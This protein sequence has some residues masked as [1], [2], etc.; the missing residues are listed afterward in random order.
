[1]DKQPRKPRKDASLTMRMTRDT[2]DRL[3]AAA[4]A[5]GRSVSEMAERWLDLAADGAAGLEQRLGGGGVS[6]ALLAMADFAAEVR[7]QVGDPGTQLVA[8][9]ALLAGWAKMISAALP[10]TPDTQEGVAARMARVEARA[11]ARALLE[12]LLQTAESD[13]HS[14]VATWAL[15]PPPSRNALAPR[16][17]RSVVQLLLDYAEA[18][19]VDEARL[20][21]ALY[22]ALQSAPPALAAIT[23]APADVAGLILEAR[24]RLAAYMGPRVA[25]RKKGEA[26]AEARVPSLRVI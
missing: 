18:S 20:S 9:D 7:G 19:G 6:E 4:N 23:P 11:A 17:G 25:A 2:R 24:E 14:E 8:R 12:A 13:L 15:T 22:G 1:M 21:D 26:L 10:F 5:E 16:D 3:E